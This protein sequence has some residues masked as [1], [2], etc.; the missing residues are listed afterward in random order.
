MNPRTPRRLPDALSGYA[1]RTKNAFEL[2]VTPGELQRQEVSTISRGV[3]AVHKHESLELAEYFEVAASVV[4][5]TLHGVASHI[6][7][8][9]LHDIP[10]PWRLPSVDKLI[11]GRSV[12][13]LV[14]SVIHVTVPA[15]Q[16]TPRRREALG[17]SQAI[18]QSEIVDAFGI[19]TTSLPRT[20]LDL[21]RW[22]DDHSLVVALD[23]L[24]SGGARSPKHS[25]IARLTRAEMQAYLKGKS[26][27]RGIKR[28]RFAIDRA[29]TGADSPP[30]TELRL[31]LEEADLPPFLAN[32]PVLDE[33]GYP[34]IWPDLSNAEF[35]VCIEYEG[36]VHLTP[37]QLHSDTNRDLRVQMHGWLQV[38]ITK[39]DMKNP[40]IAVLKV[41]SALLRNGW[42]PN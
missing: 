36:A 15:G 1:F 20:L 39:F 14:R 17:Y 13:C 2:G 31:A 26:G 4:G 18:Q 16:R 24:F 33:T 8:A 30:E 25:K 22:L 40:H 3:R 10:L 28:L 12:R 5:E 37:E 23:S 42:K 35:R 38:W 7:A 11:S 34:V 27:Q 9:R 29:V 19:P 21:T 6:T 32:V 41:R